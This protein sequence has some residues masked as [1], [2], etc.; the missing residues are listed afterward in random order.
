MYSQETIKEM[1][2]LFTDP[3]FKKNFFDFFAKVQM[4]GIEAAKKFWGMRP[5]KD[6]FAGAPEMF[7]KMVDFYI[8]LGFVPHYKYDGAVKENEKLKKEV[9]FLRG[10]LKELQASLFAEGGKQTQDLWKDIIDRQFEM[11]KE[12]AKNLFELFKSLK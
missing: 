5:E 6:I 11:N 10:T 4:E 12:M 2:D 8:I 9:E 7:E 3:L 1:M